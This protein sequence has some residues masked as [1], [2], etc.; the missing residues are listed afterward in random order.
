MAAVGTP[1]ARSPRMTTDPDTPLGPVTPPL[2]VSEGAG[3]DEPRDPA[4]A[5]GAGAPPPGD[6]SFRRDRRRRSVGWQSRDVLRTAAL[7][8]AMYV[9]IRLLWFASTLV[10]IVFLAVLFGLAVSAGVDRITRHRIGRFTVPRGIA[11]AL[12]VASFFALLAGFGAWMAPTLRDQGRELRVRLPQAINQIGE[13]V[14]ERQAGFL[15]MVLGGPAR[16]VPDTTASR[17][18]PSDTISDSLASVAAREGARAATQRTGAEPGPP[19]ATETLGTRLEGQLSGATRYL[20]PFLSSTLAVISG[21]FIVVF[22]TIYI[23]A[24]P[25]VYHNGL[26]HLFPQKSRARAGEVLSAI[27]TVLRKWLTTQLIAMLVIGTV[28]TVALTI[29]KVEAAFALGVL[30][31]LLEFV[32]TIGPILSAIP[33][34]AMGF[35]DS[36]EKAVTVTV[37]YIGIQ[38]AENQL[39]IPMLMKGG[40]DLPPA[41]TILSQALFTLLFGFLGLMVAVPAM[42]AVM[43]TVKMLYVRDVVGDDVSVMHDEDDDEEDD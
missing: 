17:T 16:R 27:A 25:K 37:L 6:A 21:F 8:I 34:I 40:V 31:G 35:L 32:P 2:D 7:V 23:A 12:I 43:V 30:A 42:A 3:R 15:G 10:I 36:P 20:F 4:Q 41:V 9:A 5:P 13:W 11:A 38:F 22:L 18:P 39:L 28:T 14:N 1:L 33:A 24:D 29:L 19:S 26:M